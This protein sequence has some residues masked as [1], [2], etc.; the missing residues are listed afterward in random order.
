[1]S[2]PVQDRSQTEIIR[3]HLREEGAITQREAA[4]EYG[5]FRLAARIYDL[6][7]EGLPVQSTLTD[8]QTRSGRI[9]Q[10]AEYELEHTQ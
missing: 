4:I 9:T 3:H 7:Q 8:V 10:V 1:M 5:I 6:R 2:V